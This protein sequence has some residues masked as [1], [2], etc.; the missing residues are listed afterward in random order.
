MSSVERGE[1]ILFRYPI[2]PEK[3]YIKRVVGLPRERLDIKDGRVFVNG[4]LVEESYVDP[5]NNRQSDISESILIPADHYF[6]MGD[7]RDNSSDSRVWGTLD[8][9]LIE[10][11]LYKTY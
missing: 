6:V 4:Q 3:R 1:I 11:K 7:N 5:D 8:K 9:A 10:G 2:D